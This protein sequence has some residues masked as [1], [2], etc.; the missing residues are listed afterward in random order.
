[1]NKKKKLAEFFLD[2]IFILFFL[3]ADIFQYLSA[4][5]ITKS[6]LSEFSSFYIALF[7]WGYLQ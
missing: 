2:Y 4:D 3:D 6:I 7:L 5:N 1:M